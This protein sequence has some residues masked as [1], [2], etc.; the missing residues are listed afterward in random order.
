MAPERLYS[1]LMPQKSRRN[2]SQAPSLCDDRI[3]PAVALSRTRAMRPCSP[4]HKPCTQDENLA[5]E[6]EKMF[7][8][9]ICWGCFVA[10]VQNL[11]SAGAVALGGRKGKEGLE[12]MVVL[13][14]MRA[15]HAMRMR[16]IHGIDAIDAIDDAVDAI[17]AI[18]AIRAM[19]GICA[20]MPCMPCV[21]CMPCMP[22]R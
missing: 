16:A 7:A 14:A 10:E 5:R 9:Q 17:H 12:C 2:S 1:I 21:P 8:V 22:Q 19:H 3:D 6:T 18:H 15:M 11:S 4:T 20:S 13:V